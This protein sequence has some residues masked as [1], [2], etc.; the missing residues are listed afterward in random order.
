MYKN[1]SQYL[2]FWL[3]NGA[4][5]GMGNDITSLNSIFGISTCRATKQITFFNSDTKL[6]CK[7]KNTYVTLRKAVTY[8]F[9]T[10]DGRKLDRG[11]LKKWFSKVDL[12]TWTWP[13]LRSNVRKSVTIE[14]YVR[15]DPQ[16]MCH[17]TLVLYFQTVTS[18][19]PILTLTST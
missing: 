4:K 12:F 8:V 9:S 1:P 18:F 5:L 13:D 2:S 10:L 11:M 3:C 17:M 16:S 14:F 15:N 6:P 7:I 19:D